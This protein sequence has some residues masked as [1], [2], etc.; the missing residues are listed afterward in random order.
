MLVYG[1]GKG[2]REIGTT[3]PVCCPNCQTTSRWSVIETS[4]HATLYFIKVARWSKQYFAACPR[5]DSGVEL[6]D[7]EHA[8]DLMSAIPSAESLN[9]PAVIHG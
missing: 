9:E 8:Q 7:R 3:G 2:A 1:W 5:C 6:R 4:R